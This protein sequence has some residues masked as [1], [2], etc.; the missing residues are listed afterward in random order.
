MNLLIKLSDVAQYGQPGRRWSAEWRDELLCYDSL[1][2]MSS[3]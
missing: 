1:L 2:L 3:L